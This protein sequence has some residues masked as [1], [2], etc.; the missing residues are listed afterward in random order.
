MII[1]AIVSQS[2]SL[3][4]FINFHYF[5]TI[6]WIFFCIYV[7]FWFS[8]AC[9]HVVWSLSL[10]RR[11]I[12]R[13]HARSLQHALFASTESDVVVFIHGARSLPTRE[14]VYLDA[15]DKRLIST[16]ATTERRSLDDAEGEGAVSVS[17]REDNVTLL[18]RPWQSR[19][20][21]DSHRSIEKFRVLRASRLL[22]RAAV[23]AVA[24]MHAIVCEICPT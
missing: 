16:P 5:F 20:R 4:E 3:W 14:A 8:V 17:T 7:Q 13:H 1:L 10:K 18:S 11:E 22:T 21:P 24:S 9:T 12:I 19:A 23:R 6:E 15:C 2:K